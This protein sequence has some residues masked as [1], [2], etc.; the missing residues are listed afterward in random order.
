MIVKRLRTSRLRPRIAGAAFLMLMLQAPP[1]TG[2]AQAHDPSP[3]GGV[4]RSRNMGDAW[5]NADIGLFLN[6]TLAL[7]VDPHDPQHLLLG[8]DIGLWRSQNGGRSWTREA[9]DLIVGAVFAVAFAPDGQSAMS[10]APNGVFRFEAGRWAQASAPSEAIPARAIAVGA[11]PGRVYLLGRSQL[12]T[13]DDDGRTYG[14]APTELPDQ[15]QITALAVTETP[16]EVLLAVIDG[17]LGT[18][19]DGGRHWLKHGEASFAGPVDMV[20]LDPYHPTRAWAGAGDRLYRSDDLGLT[21]QAFGNVLPEPQTTVRGIAANRDA[22]EIVVTTHRGMYRSDDGARTW[23]LKEGALPIHLESGPL[24]RDPSDAS[25][26]Y[27]MYSLLPYGEVWRTAVEGRNLLTRLD[28][29]SAAGGVAFV[30][31]LLGGGGGLALWLARLRGGGARS[32]H[33]PRS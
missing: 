2:V 8:T 9:E 4:F 18:S 1:I 5:L 22:T 14:A 6:A 26:L 17:G 19:E 24:T 31:L 13:S 7:A 33:Q 27:A 15:S 20:G 29:I 11:S 30:L 21:W 12:F 32:L 23:G 3:Y 28:P 10:A 25:V 16:R